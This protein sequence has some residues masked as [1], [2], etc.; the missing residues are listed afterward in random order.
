MN[1]KIGNIYWFIHAEDTSIELGI[2]RISNNGAIVIG[3]KTGSH[4]TGHGES[5][6]DKL[7]EVI[8]MNYIP[9]KVGIDLKLISSDWKAPNLT[10]S[11]R[12]LIEN[13]NIKFQLVDSCNQLSAPLQA[14]T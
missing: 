3:G 2:I 7:K 6:W 10:S 1:L 5:Y 12:K 9:V 4:L 11:D 8:A 14:D 13:M